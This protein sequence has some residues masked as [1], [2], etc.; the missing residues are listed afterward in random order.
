MT[1]WSRMCGRF[2]TPPYWPTPNFA[3]NWNAAA[4]DFASSGAL[5]LVECGFKIFG[6]CTTAASRTRS[7]AARGPSEPAKMEE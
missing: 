2:S 6:G 1:I 3:P 7:F 5:D 4:A